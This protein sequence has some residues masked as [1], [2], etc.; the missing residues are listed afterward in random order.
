MRRKRKL[1]AGWINPGRR[2]RLSTVWSQ[3]KKIRRV[4]YAVAVITALTALAAF[5]AEDRPPD[6]IGPNSRVWVATSTDLAA[7]NAQLQTRTALDPFAAPDQAVA[8]QPQRPP[9]RIEEVATGMNFWDGQTWASSE[10]SFDVAADAFVANRLQY[11][12]SISFNLNTVS[13]VNV[14]TRDGVNIH[15]TPVAIGLYDAASGASTII[16]GITNCSGVMVNSNKVTFENAFQG[17]SADLV[18]TIERGSFHQDAVIRQR[19]DPADYGFPRDTTRIQIFTEVYDTPAPEKIRRPLYVE[20]DE[21]IRNAKASPDVVDEVLGWGEFVLAT[22]RAFDSQ[23]DQSSTNATAPVPKELKTISGR[24]FIV[25]SVDYSQIKVQLQALPEAAQQGASLKKAF[26]PAKSRSQ[27]AAI[28]K[29]SG[30]RQQAALSTP[31]AAVLLAKAAPEKRKGVT[32]DYIAD[33]G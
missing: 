24:T 25:E 12:A 26:Q 1:P 8:A 33:V 5:A 14:I 11:L 13:A 20:E 4:F 21:A 28:P 6:E 30:K 23:I 3:G 31:K 17:I 7:S 27:Y 22:G 9:S 16:A 2:E 29:A 32:I 18:Y 15:S 19:L 10:A